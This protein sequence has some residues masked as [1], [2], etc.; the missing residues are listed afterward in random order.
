MNMIRRLHSL[1]V[2]KGK[3]RRK[4]TSNESLAVLRVSSLVMNRLYSSALGADGSGE[5]ARAFTIV[6]A[7]RVPATIGSSIMT[8]KPS[9]PLN[10]N[11]RVIGKRAGRRRD[12]AWISLK[13]LDS[14]STLTQRTYI[15]R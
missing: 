2:G 12:N 10:Q 7:T 15:P 4:T 3:E 11:R 9:A 13:R 14:Y 6:V 5:K 8:M 1:I